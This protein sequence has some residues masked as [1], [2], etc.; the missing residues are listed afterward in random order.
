V[1]AGA[2]GGRVVAVCEGAPVIS[3]NCVVSEVFEGSS[4][5]GEIRCGFPT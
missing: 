2:R 1:D 4:G 5:M 3:G